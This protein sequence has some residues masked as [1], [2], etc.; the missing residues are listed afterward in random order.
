M[1]P[2]ARAMLELYGLHVPVAGDPMH[3]E[4]IET[5]LSTMATAAQR[6]HPS[7]SSRPVSSA[8]SA[9]VPPLPAPFRTRQASKR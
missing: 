5:P 4:P 1:S 3:V 2:T 8:M 9:R 6:R 7:S